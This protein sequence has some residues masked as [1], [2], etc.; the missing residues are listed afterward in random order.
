MASFQHP[1]VFTG[2]RWGRRFGDFDE[3]AHHIS[4]WDVRYEQLS[5]GRF[6]ADIAMSTSPRLQIL[7][8]VWNR[9]LSNLGAPPAGRRSFAFRSAAPRLP[10]RRRRGPTRT[11]MTSRGGREFKSSPGRIRSGVRH[12]RPRSDRRADPCALR[13]RRSALVEPRLT[14]SPHA[15]PWRQPRRRSTRSAGRWQARYQ[16]L[17][18]AWNRRRPT[19]FSPPWHHPTLRPITHRGA[20]WPNASRTS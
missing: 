16:R 20:D 4:A 1:R 18:C 12:L 11:L 8:L 15:T 10:L 9:A 19:S 6:Q 5:P 17:S 7:T 13:L 14:C 2:M 3:M